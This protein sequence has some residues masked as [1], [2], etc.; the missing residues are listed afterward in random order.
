[1]IIIIWPAPR[2]TK[3]HSMHRPHP[4][5]GFSANWIMHVVARP[6]HDVWGIH[7]SLWHSRGCRKEASPY[8]KQT[9][10]VGLLFWLRI[11]P[12]TSPSARYFRGKREMKYGF[13]MTKN[14]TLLVH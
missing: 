10:N 4:R 5:M 3:T 11:N 7:E 14:L 12:R 13:V 6:A 8:I 2:F 1:M 9:P